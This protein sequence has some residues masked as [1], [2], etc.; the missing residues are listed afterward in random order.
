LKDDDEE[1][2]FLKTNFRNFA[3]F[4]CNGERFCEPLNKFFSLKISL[5]EFTI[6][7]LMRHTILAQPLGGT[8]V[9]YQS[10]FA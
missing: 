8:V 7:S 3:L 9:S 4:L 2:T 10:C 5:E 1:K 6:V